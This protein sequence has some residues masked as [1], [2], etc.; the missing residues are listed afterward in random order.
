MAGTK[1]AENFSR[2]SIFGVDSNMAT[3]F[4]NYWENFVLYREFKVTKIPT[5]SCKIFSL[6]I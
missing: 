6:E 5:K 2:F 3:W 1:S 4:L